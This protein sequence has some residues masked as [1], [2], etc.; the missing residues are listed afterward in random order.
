MF[1]A[2]HNGNAARQSPACAQLEV[3]L[4]FWILDGAEL[5]P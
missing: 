2:S 4:F 3:L 1:L 5:D